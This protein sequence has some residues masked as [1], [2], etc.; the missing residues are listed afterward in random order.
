MACG[1]TKLQVMGIVR[2][3]IMQADPSITTLTQD[4]YLDERG[5]GHT[6]EKRRS[7]FLYIRDSVQ[8]RACRLA[9]LT[10]ASMNKDGIER[11]RDI[12]ELVFTDLQ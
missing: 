11:V 4:T 1:L 7:Y 5:L 12:S 6:P 8:T 3:A 9:T 2:A 10:A